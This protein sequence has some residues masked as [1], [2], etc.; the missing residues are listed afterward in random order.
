MKKIFLLGAGTSQATAPSA[1]RDL[2]TGE[3]FWHCRTYAEKLGADKVYILSAVHGLLALDQLVEPYKKTLKP[4]NRLRNPDL[5]AMTLVEINT[6]VEK[7]HGQLSLIAD[8][9][10]DIFVILGGKMYA[11][12]LRPIL[13]HIEQPL[14]GLQYDL[15][16]VFLQEKIRELDK[17]GKG[18]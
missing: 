12:L 4:K 7:V 14:K 6:W 11:E 10:K 13:T 5:Q 17:S 2:Y 9:E 3:L 18:D 16:V 15:A 1:A 8:L